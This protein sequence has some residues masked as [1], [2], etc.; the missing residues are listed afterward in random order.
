[1]KHNFLRRQ[2]S[3]DRLLLVAADYFMPGGKR[4]FVYFVFVFHIVY[5]VG[6]WPRYSCIKRSRSWKPS[7]RFQNGKIASP[8]IGEECYCLF[9][10]EILLNSLELCNKVTQRAVFG[11]HFLSYSLKSIW[12]VFLPGKTNQFHLHLR[13]HRINVKRFLLLFT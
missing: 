10:K 11:K 4:H 8:D 3:G 9:Y 5:F 13:F 1:M 7:K 2:T 6:S 12:L